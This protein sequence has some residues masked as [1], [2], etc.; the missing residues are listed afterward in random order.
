MLLPL[1]SAGRK[2][3]S[4]VYGRLAGILLISRAAGTPT[5]IDLG[6]SPVMA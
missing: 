4:S 3:D 2:I 6:S 1:V 5:L